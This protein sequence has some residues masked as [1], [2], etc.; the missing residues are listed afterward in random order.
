MADLMV[1]LLA[2]MMVA[3]KVCWRVGWMAVSMVVRMA[4]SRVAW[5]AVL[6]ELQWVVQLVAR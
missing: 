3:Q 1:G 6:T 4:G 5:T 2:V